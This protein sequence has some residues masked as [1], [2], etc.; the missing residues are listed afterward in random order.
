MRATTGL[1]LAVLLVAL[2]APDALRADE[3]TCGR[4]DNAYGPYDYTNAEHRERYMP[5]VVRAH[6]NSDVE[7]LRRGQS[8]ASPI[9]DI[10]YTL[11]AFPNHHRALDAASRWYLQG[12]TAN[13]NVYS[14]ECYFDRA[15]R[16]SPRD[17]QVYLLYGTY[18]HRR[19]DLAGAEAQYAQAIALMPES[20]DAHYNLGLL[21]AES[22]RWELARKE[23][24]A[25]YQAGHPLQGLK[26][27]LRRQGHWNDGDDAALMAAARRTEGDS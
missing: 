11:R 1:H 9:D 25:A 21:Y 5:V 17:G 16:F 8:S 6:F 7:T 13:A 20:A 15:I 27:R 22:G 3:L 26:K 2:S 23:A 19:K 10:H 18:L 12:G 14:A 24:F 4:L